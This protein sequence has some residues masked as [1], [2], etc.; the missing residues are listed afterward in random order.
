M[1]KPMRIPVGPFSKEDL[2]RV[3]DLLGPK[4]QGLRNIGVYKDEIV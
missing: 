4:F 1:Q 3:F 2:K